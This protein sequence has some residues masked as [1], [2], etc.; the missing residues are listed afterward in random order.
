MHKANK[1]KYD[2]QQYETIRSFGKSIYNGKIN[3]D[4]TKMGQSKL[5]ENMVE[6][7]EKSILRKKKIR[8]KKKYFWKCKCSLRWS[9]INSW[10][11]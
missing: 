2:F 7:N 10:C 3:I 8:K 11:F 6:F 4:E 5:L 9:R 1:Y